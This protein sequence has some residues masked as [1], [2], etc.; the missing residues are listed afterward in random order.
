MDALVRARNPT[1]CRAA[2]YMACVEQDQ[3]TTERPPDTS[4]VD[5]V[6]SS[7]SKQPDF[8]SQKSGTIRSAAADNLNVGNTV[9][10]KK[11]ELAARLSI[12]PRTVD[13]LV[14]KRAIPYLA[15]SPRLH[16]F[17]PAA[18]QEAMSVRFEVRAREVR[19]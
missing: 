7:V 8:I 4:Q 6:G 19:Q 17:D 16:L 1:L 2:P 15:L 14:A 10:I 5:T 9:L 3:A 11:K 18:V 12:S 13:D